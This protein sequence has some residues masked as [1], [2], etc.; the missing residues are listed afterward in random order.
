MNERRLLLH[1]K[2]L[3][4]N[5]VKAAY[6]NPTNNIKMVYPC[7]RYSLVGEAVRFAANGRY[8]TRDRYLVTVIDPDPDSQIY[9]ELEKNPYYSFERMY[10]ADGLCHFTGSIY[11]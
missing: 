7:I 1:Q 3:S 10:S 8:I 9:K 6:F 5:R 11:F 2:F 4:I